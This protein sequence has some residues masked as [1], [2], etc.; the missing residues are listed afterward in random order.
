MAE[1]FSGMRDILFGY[2][3]DIHFS[4]GD[5]QTT[6]GLDYIEREIYKVLISDK[7]DWKTSPNLGASLSSFIGQKNNRETA[8]GIK[9][10]VEKSLRSTVYP[11]SLNVDVVPVNES[12]IMVV[13][14]ILVNGNSIDRFPFEFDFVNGFKKVS[15]RDAQVTNTQSSNNYKINDIS[16]MQNYNKYYER[17]RN[18]RT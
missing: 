10:Y 16:K 8:E 13:I 3:T 5:L 15:L 17:Q 4:G 2:D 9:S 6:S 18:N 1:P 7:G 12:R 14:N 11:A